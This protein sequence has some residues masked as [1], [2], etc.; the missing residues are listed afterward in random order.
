M[1]RKN[2]DRPLGA[3]LP[4]ALRQSETSLQSSSRRN[5]SPEGREVEERKGV[6][7]GTGEV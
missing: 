4:R 5:R 3:G 1:A 6:E 7:N 2:Q